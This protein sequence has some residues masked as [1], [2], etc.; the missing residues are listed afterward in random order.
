M[1]RRARRYARAMV[2][3]MSYITIRL[4]QRLLTWFWNRIY[5]GIDARGIERIKLLAETVDARV[6]AVPSQPRRLPR[7]VVSAVQPGTDDSA[8]R[9]RR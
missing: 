1:T 2:S 9:G 5:D 8:R 6:R 4:L 7:V 3:D